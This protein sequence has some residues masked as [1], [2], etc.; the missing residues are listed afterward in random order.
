MFD[1]VV[2]VWGEVVDETVV[3]DASGLFETRHA[4]LDLNIDKPIRHH[5]PK[6]ILKYDFFRN[7]TDGHSH[8]FKIFEGRAVV[9][10][11]DVDGAEA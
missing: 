3:G 6:I 4:L 8:V 11:F 1:G 9:E 7:D 10:V 2:A 5:V